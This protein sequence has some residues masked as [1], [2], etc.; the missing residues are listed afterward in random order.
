MIDLLGAVILLFLI[1]RQEVKRRE[2]ENAA[3][4]RLYKY[5]EEMKNGNQG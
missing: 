2:A 3:K 4:Q 5:L 1:I